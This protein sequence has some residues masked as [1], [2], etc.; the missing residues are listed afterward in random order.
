MC[1]GFER[2]GIIKMNAYQRVGNM[3]FNLFR[4]HQHR[5]TNKK[6]LCRAPR[7]VALNCAIVE[8]VFVHFDYQ[9]HVYVFLNAAKTSRVYKN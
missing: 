5:T 8:Q 4:N 6:C 9:L 1:E 7:A 2:R 3:L